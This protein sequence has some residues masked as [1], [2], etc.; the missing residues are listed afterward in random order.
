VEG[1]HDDRLL[2]AWIGHELQDLRVEI[3]PLRGGSKLPATIESRV[4]F[5]STDAHLFAILDHVEPEE[6]NAVW[7]QLRALADG[8]P[9]AA[10]EQL[11]DR[12]D[13]RSDE[14]SWLT[15]W[16]SRAL[17][18]GRDK[19]VT[20]YALRQRDIIEYLPAHVLVRGASDWPSLRQE[21]ERAL[22]AG[23]RQKDFKK[24]LSAAK[25]ARFDPATVESAAMD[26]PPPA[27]VLAF[28]DVVRQTVQGSAEAPNGTAARSGE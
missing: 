6:L 16:L 14:M 13:V 22:H 7:S 10:V 2:R 21:H 18:S 17:T 5:D 26:V 28:L 12:L 4:L 19:R 11:L 9:D 20:P 27:E 15:E 3:L 8:R 24:W 23:A 1:E 25:K